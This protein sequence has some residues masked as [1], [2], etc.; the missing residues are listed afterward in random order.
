MARAAPT[1]NFAHLRAREALAPV[2]GRLVQQ[3]VLRRVPPDPV[4]AALLQ[5]RARVVGQQPVVAKDRAVEDAVVGRLEH[6]AL[7]VR[8]AVVPRL[9]PRCA[10]RPPSAGVAFE[11]L[12]STGGW[13]TEARADVA[14]EGVAA[15]GEGEVGRREAEE[16]RAALVVRRPRQRPVRRRLPHSHA[17]PVSQRVW[18]VKQLAHLCEDDDLV[19]AAVSVRRPR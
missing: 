16:A 4:P 11:L 12:C 6:G 14:V 18:M 5:H 8:D 13:L 15:A 1:T 3:V 9:R 7:L 2:R 17:D 19:A 10:R